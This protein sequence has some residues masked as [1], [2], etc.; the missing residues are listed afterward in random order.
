MGDWRESAKCRGMDAD[1]FSYSSVDDED[2][3]PYKRSWKLLS[4]FNNKKLRAAVAICGSCPV[5]AACRRTAE[6]V[7]LFYTVRGGELPGKLF[8]D[9]W[10]NAPSFKI[11]DYIPRPKPEEDRWS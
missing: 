5:R 9:K 1:A 3:Q 2:A 7:D 11:L 10:V 4:D 8:A 6:E